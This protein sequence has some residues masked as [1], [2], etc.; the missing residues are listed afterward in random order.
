MTVQAELPARWAPLTGGTEVRSTAPPTP[1]R[2]TPGSPM[3]WLRRLH[4]KLEARQPSLDRF[5][6][7]YRGDHPLP[8]LSPGARDEFRRV[9]RMTRAN[10]MGLV[11]D[12]QVERMSVEGFRLADEPAADRNTW[13]IWQVNHLDADFRMVLKESAIG[14]TAYMLVGPNPDDSDKPIISVEHASQAITEAAP[15]ARRRRAAGLK[16]WVDDWTGGLRADLYVPGEVHRFTARAVAAEPLW[17]PMDVIPDPLGVVPLVDFPNA[18]RMLTGGVS[19]LADLTDSQDRVNKTLADRIITQDYGADPQKW[20]TGY[21]DQ[22]GTAGSPLQM[23]RNR[24][25]TT[26]VA[27]TRFGQWDAAPLD[28][29]SSAK[30]ED[31]KDIASRSRTPAQYLLGEMTNVNGET[32]KAAESGLVA[33]V[34]ERRFPHGEQLEEVMRLARRR[35]G[36]AGP[37]ETMET[38]WRNPEFRTEGETVDALTKMA[39]LGV[40]RRAL[41]ERWGATPLEMDR[42]EQMADAELTRAALADP[43]LAEVAQAS[44]ALSPTSEPPA[45]PGVA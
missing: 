31:V 25:I 15:G 1:S 5:D 14:G 37:A 4:R 26:D 8:W 7:Y 19:E 42:W 10:Y 28:P 32:L 23:G 40:P 30:R 21:P 36:L 16:V 41:W 39:T 29:Y 2:L 34:L 12:A 35:A 38:I 27:E 9:L 24:L 33:K 22:D 6:A 43:L 11:V 17:Q 18:P 3:W 13:L 20:G 44:R 45:A